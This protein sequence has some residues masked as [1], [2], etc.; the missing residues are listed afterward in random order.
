[1]KKIVLVFS[2]LLF[3]QWNIAAQITI[4]SS[5]VANTLVAK[6]VGTGVTYSNPTLTCATNGAGYFVSTNAMLGIDSGVL[7]TTGYAKNNGGNV[8][9]N[10]PANVQA[11]ANRAYTVG[12]VDLYNLA[13]TYNTSITTA[14]I[15]DVC[16]LEFDFIPQGDTIRFNYK[17]A[18]EEYPD[19]VCSDFNDYFAFFIN[20]TPG[21]PTAT[22]LAKVP[23]TNIPVAINTINSGSAGIPPATLSNCTSMGIGSPFSAYFQNTASS[24]T[25]VYN[26]TTV[27]LEAKAAVT[28]CSTYHMKFVVAD[29]VDHNYDSGVF[30]KSGSFKSDAVVFDSIHSPTA[31]P[32]NWPY[33]TEGCNSDTIYIRRAKPLPTAQTIYMTIG[34]TATNGLDY[35]SIPATITIPANDTIAKLVITPIA[36]GIPEPIETLT[37]GLKTVACNTFF[38]DTMTLLIN[39]F[40]NYQVTDNDTICIGDS[41]TLAAIVTPTD[42][43]ISFKW[44]PGNITA[45]SINITPLS[46][47]TYTVTARYPGCANRDS[48][49]K[50]N[51]STKP[52]VNAGLDT[53]L[54]IGSSYTITAFGNVT[55]PYPISYSWNPSS[56]LSSSTALTT[57]ATPSNTTTYTITAVNV[58]GCS[59]SDAITINAKPGITL[60]HI[61]NPV[62]CANING[63]ITVSNSANATNISY[64]LQPGNITTTTGIFTNINGNA[65]YTITT[66][67]AAYCNTSTTITVPGV[68]PVLITSFS[69]N[70]I[71]CNGNNTGSA[72]VVSSG[73]GTITYNL[74]P[75]NTNNTIGSFANLAA[76]NYTIIAVDG[77]SCSTSTTFS[78]T[79]ASPLLINTFTTTNVLCNA[80][81]TGNIQIAASGGTSAIN[82][83]LQPTSTNNTSGIFNTL[84]ANT[85]TAV[86]TDGN[87][88]TISTATTITQPAPIVIDSVVK[89]LAICNPTNSG[90][91]TIYVSGGV[92]ITT[93]NAVSFAGTFTASGNVF[94]NLAPNT[95]TLTITDGNACTKAQTFTIAQVAIPT[96][97]GTIAISPLCNNIANGSIST[98]ISNPNSTIAYTI[99]PSITNNANGTFSNASA[100]IYTISLSDANN[101]TATTI[102]SVTQP[103]P[104]S[105]TTA[106]A[107]PALCNSSLTGTVNVTA[108]GGVGSFVYTLLNN[109][110][111][112]TT[113]SFTNLGA[114]IYTV[115]TIDGNGCTK[116][117]ILTVTQPTVLAITNVIG[118][119]P[120]C[121]NGNNGQISITANG[122]TGT[123]AYAINGGTSQSLNTFVGLVGNA[124]YTLSIKDANNC[125]ATSTCYLNQP[126]ALQFTSV[127]A[128]SVHCWN[129]TDGSIIA[130]GNGGTGTITYSIYPLSTNNTTGV[131]NNLFSS[132]YTVTIT[133][134]NGCSHTISTIVGQPLAL[135]FTSITTTPVICAGTS[136][137]SITALAVGGFGSYTY[138]LANTSAS[139]ASGSFSNLAGGVYTIKVVDAVGCSRVSTTTLLEPNTLLFANISKQNNFCFGDVAGLIG[140]T[141]S[142]G[143]GGN[144]YII[145]PAVF[146]PNTNGTFYP[147]PSNTYT[148]NAIDV[149]GCTTNTIITITQPSALI[150]AITINSPSCSN[151]TNGNI[152]C[153]VSGG[154]GN[155]SFTL[156][157]NN[158]TNA[159]GFFGNLA[160]G[161]YS[162]LITDA[163]GCDTTNL[164]TLINPTP[165]AIDSF[166]INKIKCYGDSSGSVNVFTSGGTGT[167]TFQLLPLAN[168]NNLGTFTNLGAGVY[169]VVVTDTKNC[170]ANTFISITQN[171]LIQFSAVQLIN[172]YCADGNQGKISF[173]AIGGVAPLQYSFNN[174]AFTSNTTYTNLTLGIYSITIKDAVGCILDTTFSLNT[175]QK[176]ILDIDSFQSV[177]CPGVKDATIYAR[178][179]FGNPG[180]YSYVLLPVNFVNTTGTF[181]GVPQGTFTVLAVDALGCS[182][183]AT[184]TIAG[185]TDTIHVDFTITPISCT[186]YATDGKI[187][188]MPSGG[189]SPYLYSW[190]NGTDANKVL[191]SVSYGYYIVN[192]VDRYGCTATDTAYMPPSN[193]C[194][195]FIPN[196]FTPNQ[197][198]LNDKLIPKT[199]ASITIINYDVFDRFGN[200]VFGTVVNGEGWDGTYKKQKLD[201]DTY[202]YIFNYRCLHDNKTYLLK[203]DVLLAR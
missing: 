71:A 57:V 113:G 104:I 27:L 189:N 164:A 151:N 1:M 123:I 16:K 96:F 147:L 141:T 203:G 178:A 201:I 41:K 127:I 145:N 83:T 59:S 64:T 67:S 13:H 18:S 51:V 69:K 97:T 21:Y 42:T 58:A 152:T 190:N 170:S 165:L 36:D 62:N 9:A 202:F 38:S 103:S 94:T 49:I 90:T 7:L 72:N 193:C 73:V 176:L 100:N 148:I 24:N 167:L 55:N 146:S 39:E 81:N 108:S 158:I 107:S 121:Y 68:T 92:G 114:A 129:T 140:V 112:N 196:A 174:S 70:N 53:N 3:I 179:T 37:I 99:N 84:P 80:A 149:K 156:L 155:Y 199:S 128:D 168:S 195:V 31:L 191:D 106:S 98:T 19:Y 187:E 46:T 117:T 138:T 125:I 200:K 5:T 182:N 29:L 26:G 102:V 66:S 34:G 50:V 120:T 197:D 56:T 11:G 160:G 180:G 35:L 6:L 60:S 78:I 133:D 74:S 116:S 192:I 77:Q 194:E 115:Q 130:A 91:A 109:S 25:I 110:A 28:P 45:N 105:F 54:C 142:G 153:T 137:G 87:G 61:I 157:P 2:L 86:V 82:Y 119:I 4:T 171:N 172:P 162:V 8:G 93:M 48:V 122:G 136:T 65:T 173:N 186:G 33:S 40:P 76:G 44:N 177:I 88:C 10:N 132:I 134:A 79:Q 22:N 111:S 30:L 124:T 15:N 17:F 131:F 181:T 169:T 154:A 139:N 85:Y 163:N 175:P 161:N 20:G 159:T 52:T 198:G 95:Y 166:T 89:T 12:D 126:P 150:P 144:N 101:C 135:N 43:N 75:N 63:T 23:G 32:F 183:S 118:T 185:S 47:N 184:I 143:N 188:A 14:D